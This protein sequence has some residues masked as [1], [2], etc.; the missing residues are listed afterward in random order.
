MKI[1]A[2][3]AIILFCFSIF[4]C[5]YG[6]KIA[7]GN[8]IAAKVENFKNENGKLPD[9]L[10]DI[11]VK[12]T[13]NDIAQKIQKQDLQQKL[14]PAHGQQKMIRIDGR[15]SF[16]ARSPHVKRAVAIDK[17]QTAFADDL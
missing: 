7:Q 10:S 2:F 5:S 12:E 1:E 13:E 11:G 9:S 3:T 6:E 15:I 17:A 16:D 14:F 4:A 8:E